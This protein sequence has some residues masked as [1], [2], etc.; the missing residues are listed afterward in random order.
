MKQPTNSLNI[1]IFYSSPSPNYLKYLKQ[2][3]NLSMDSDLLIYS[4]DNKA[5]L[6]QLSVLTN[7][8]LDLTSNNN[9]YESVLVYVENISLL[10]NTL[11]Q[12]KNWF[13]IFECI[14]TQNIV[15][16]YK[17][18]L[19]F[20]KP[21][22][23]YNVSCNEKELIIQYTQTDNILNNKYYIYDNITINEF[24]DLIIRVNN[25]IQIFDILIE[26]RPIQ[27]N[28]IYI[29]YLYTN[30]QPLN[31]IIL[32]KNTNRF[33]QINNTLNSLLNIC[34]NNVNTPLLK[35]INTKMFQ[36]NKKKILEYISLK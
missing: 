33:K 32:L 30:A 31:S 7:L 21:L 18:T 16:V 11:F 28:N 13:N 36:L 15:I 26:R 25:K 6:G 23:N 3:V 22:F 5:E 27:D 10:N 29:S 2:F 1:F 24:F 4:I 35:K 17:E 19:L 20:K 9:E 8:I 34:K 14:N 12:D